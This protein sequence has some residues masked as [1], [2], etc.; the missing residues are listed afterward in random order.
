MAKTQ[1]ERAVIDLVINGQQAK[2]NLKEITLEVTRQR[3]AL[4]KL[5]EA[6]NPEFYKAKLAEYHKML[7]AQKQMRQRI[8]DTTTA[9]GRFKKEMAQVAVGVVG[10]NVITAA[11]QS[12][13]AL[14]PST[15]DRT[16]KLKDTFADI[17]KATNLSAAGVQKLNQELKAIDTRT[18][19]Q[20]LR[21]IAIAGGQLGVPNAELV[22]FVENVDQ[23]VVALGDEF[24]GGVDEVAKSLGGIGKLF[25][26]T[27]NLPAGQVINDVGSALNELGAAGS[28]TSAVVA[29]FTTRMGQLGALAPKLAETMGLG[30]ALQELGLSAEIAS[31]GLTGLMLTA[32]NRSELFAQHLGLSKVALEQLINT[33]PNEFLMTL[34]RSFEG[35]APAA[36]AQRLKE[37]KVESQESIKV[38]S[39]LADQT[40]FVKEKQ[41]LAAKAMAEGT[42]LTEEFTKKNHQL[43][44]DLKELNEWFNSLLTSEALQQFLVSALHNLVLFTRAL[45]QAGA[46]LSGMK[47]YFYG[48]M[49]ATVAYY[50]ATL[51]ATAATV[52]HTTAELYRR[53]AY[54][55][56][57]RWLVITETAT[58]AYALTTQV[59]T[60][61]IT[62]QTAAVTLARTAWTAFNAILIA[63]PIGV[64]LTGL[65]ALAYAV[66]TYSDN[67][68]QAL[69]LEREK[70]RLQR[71]MTLLTEVQTRT[72]DK[73]NEQLQD[74]TAMS[75][76]ERA[77]YVKN[78]AIARLDLEARLSRMK[79]RAKEM[80]M[81]ALEPSLWQKL[82][83][84]IKAGG[85]MAAVPKNLMEQGLANVLAVRQQFEGGIS[86]LTNELKQYDTILNQ[87]QRYERPAPGRD[88]GASTTIVSEDDR[89]AAASKQKADAKRDADELEKLLGDSRQR[90][91]EGEASD[92]EREVAAFAEKY[93]RM[94]E[95][96]KD[97]QDKIDEIQRLSLV[98]FAEIERR[99]QELLDESARRQ[100][101]RDNKLGYTAALGEAE[102]TRAGDQT[103]IGLDL[104]TKKIGEAEARQL[105][106]ES[107]QRFLEQKLLLQ[108]TFAQEV[109][110]TQRQLTENWNAQVHLRAQTEYDAAERMKQAEWALADAKRDA[111]LQG[112]T[113]LKAFLKEGTRAYKVALAAQ[114]AFAI[115]QV[116]IDMQRQIVGLAASP[117]VMA[118][119]PGVREAYLAKSILTAKIQAGSAIAAIAAQGAT[120]IAAKADGG[121]TG[122][123]ELYPGSAGPA[124]FTDGPTLF[125]MGRRS[126]IAGEAGREFVIS[127]RALQHPVVADFA[128]MLDAM[129]RTGNYAALSPTQ[130]AI[131][132][133]ADNSRGSRDHQGL[134]LSALVA[135]LQTL[136]QDINNLSSRPV[137]LNYHLFKQETELI[138]YIKTSNRL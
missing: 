23:A 95:L 18:T 126:Y 80:E 105:E 121:Y 46:F 128:R 35:M 13:V 1:T 120:E 65:A 89:R 79:A 69:R 68:E 38:M 103:R 124:G 87:I 10:G 59:L 57:F 11:L 47:D 76:A 66:K 130:G 131:P 99:R 54:E 127:N 84:V 113:L 12:L 44:R 32:A 138:D 94:Y 42:S 106:L 133:A 123:E 134:E 62:L 102:Q 17:E 24:S 31:S 28:A 112:T 25:A 52:A 98:E 90:I 137:E 53:A 51:K 92:Y 49:L 41:D 88:G 117:S 67:T 77:E 132:P 119:P 37:L 110:D 8:D 111:Y 125:N 43:A 45:P 63:N 36:V 58:K 109:T 104:A 20:E 108:Q 97:H 61:Q 55:L 73:L 93:T 91:A 114:K 70:L 116:I 71:D 101:E 40:G 107:E 3:S 118:M 22:E 75:Q 34:A 81:L 56:G 78:V 14:I 50:G 6:D 82:W 129:Q 60:G 26:E 5:K 15:I 33:S 16:L 83:A 2:T 30:A 19:N 64:V 21:E 74:Y 48:L 27:R 4:L 96:A 115:A 136:R 7:A 122:L 86:G 29:E 135:E 72:L 9:W 100:A 85:N 39:L